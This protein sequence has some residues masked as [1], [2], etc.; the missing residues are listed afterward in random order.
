[1]ISYGNVDFLLKVFFLTFLPAVS[2]GQATTIIAGTGEN[3]FSGDNGPATVATLNQPIATTVDRFGNIYIVDVGNNNIRK[4]SSDGTITTFIG[5]TAHDPMPS[6]ISHI[7]IDLFQQRIQKPHDI[8]VDDSGN[9]YFP[10]F[11]GGTVRKISS[12]GLVTYIAGKPNGAVYKGDSNL[13]SNAILPHLQGI[14][15]DPYGCIYLACEKYN[16]I[17]KISRSGFIS[18]IAGN[19]ISGFSGDG[20]AAVD[21]ELNSPWGVAVDSKANVYIADRGNNRIRKIDRFGRISTIAGTGE[22]GYIGDSGLAI[23]ATLNEP[24]GISID[25]FGNLYIADSKNDAI[26]VID[27]DGFITTI[28]GNSNKLDSG[29]RPKHNKVRNAVPIGVV[30]KSTETQL[31]Y[32]C[33]VAVDT[34]GNLYVADNQNHVIR[35]VV[36][37]RIKKRLIE[38][39]T[40]SHKF[41]NV[42]PDFSQDIRNI[43]NNMNDSIST[44]KPFYQEVV[45]VNVDELGTSLIVS[46]FR[47]DYVRYTITSEKDTIVLEGDLNNNQTKIDLKKLLVGQYHLNLISP[48]KIKTILFVKN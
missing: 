27:R 35:K 47:T 28:V 6:T 25:N 14:A 30:Q 3:G 39:D 36:I 21:A 45:R 15:F 34:S 43:V 44:D 13:A 7:T 40:I 26:R 37:P 29:D 19:G 33:D 32:P 41:N 31:N 11:E 12:D 2:Y 24:R 5:N 1:M 16:A 48:F 17:Y 20:G 23:N 38:T 8:V 22:K 18:Q 9:V 4:V 42:N 10:E 46:M